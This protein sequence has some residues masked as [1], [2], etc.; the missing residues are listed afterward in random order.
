MEAR[1]ASAYPKKE[2]D[3][4]SAEDIGGAGNVDSMGDTAKEEVAVRR[5]DC[6]WIR[7]I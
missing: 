6:R 7:S 2:I 4:S 1:N 3:G 5:I